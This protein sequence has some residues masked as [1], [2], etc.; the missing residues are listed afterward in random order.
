MSPWRPP[1]STE[2]GCEHGICWKRC[3]KDSYHRYGLRCYSTDN[4]S[5]STT[6]KCKRKSDCNRCW[7]C[8]I[9]CDNIPF[10]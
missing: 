10:T 3:G 7:Q 8:G 5:L 4:P 9:P 1:C 6:K 2:A